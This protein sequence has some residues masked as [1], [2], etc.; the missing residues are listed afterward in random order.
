RIFG[1]LQVDSV[2]RLGGDS[3]SI[4][5][6]YPW[7][8]DHPHLQPGW[9]PSNTVY[10]ARER[11]SLF[12]DDLKLPGWG[13]FRIGH[14]LTALGSTKPTVWSVPDWLNPSKGG[15]GMTFHPSERWSSDGFVRSASRGQEFVANIADRQD[16]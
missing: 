10:L 16:A 15:T 4:V 8:A 3:A 7:L 9:P 14:R 6:R 2:L 13:V 12:G 11:L 5:G 1:W